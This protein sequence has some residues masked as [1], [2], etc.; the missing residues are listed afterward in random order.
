MQPACKAVYAF[1]Y[2]A[3]SPVHLSTLSACPA[4]CAVLR[5]C[6]SRASCPIMSAPAADTC[7]KAACY[8]QCRVI[9]AASGKAVTSLL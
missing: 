5:L 7:D 4:V 1:L 3:L 9:F 6:A 2:V 8:Q